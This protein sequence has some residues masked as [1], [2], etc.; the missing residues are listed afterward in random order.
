MWAWSQSPFPPVCVSEKC[1]LSVD[2]TGGRADRERG[3]AAR[4]VVR[5]LGWESRVSRT[6]QSI[7]QSINPSLNREGEART[8]RHGNG[9]Q[10]RR[11]A[12]VENL[13]GIQTPTASI[14]AHMHIWIDFSRLSFFLLSYAHFY[15]PLLI[16]QS[17]SPRVHHRPPATPLRRPGILNPKLTNSS[18]SCRF[19][20]AS[21]S[22]S[23][24]RTR[25][26]SLS[27]VK[28]AT[29]AFIAGIIWPVDA[30]RSR[31]ALQRSCRTSACG[32]SCWRYNWVCVRMCIYAVETWFKLD[33]F[34]GG[35]S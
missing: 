9:T 20:S 12:S 22:T 1:R 31:I 18:S 10:A 27:P 6:R 5:V 23:G 13:N 29:A 14:V 25:S 21:S 30:K 24:G 4:S 26:H 17:H 7:P 2:R 16:L 28:C 8:F 15:H 32:V 33:S 34:H 19:F 3:R 11:N 35:R